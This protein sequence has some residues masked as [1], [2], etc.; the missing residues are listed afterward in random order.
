MEKIQGTGMLIKKIYDRMVKNANNNLRPLHL[1]ISQVHV[2]HILM[3]SPEKE[4][5][6][7]QIERQ[8]MIQSSTS[9]GLIT[10]MKEKGVVTTH[11]CQN[12]A[13]I[14][15][16]KI[17]D[18][19]ERLVQTVRGDILKMEGQLVSRM[20]KEEAEMFYPLLEKAL[21]SINE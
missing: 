8:L 21:A 17:T 15:V 14:T 10:R 6:M 20:T 7:K 13:R 11:G 12:D 18:A 9:T 5:T 1:T 16:V 2:L 19:G 4:L 3:L